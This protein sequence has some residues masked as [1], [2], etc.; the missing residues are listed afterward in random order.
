MFLINNVALVARCSSSILFF[1]LKT[2]EFTKDTTWF[3][4]RTLNIR[5]FLYFIK[6]N[7]RIQIT[8]D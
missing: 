7:K 1:K 2:D 3:N 6:G 5:G 4:Y 8:T